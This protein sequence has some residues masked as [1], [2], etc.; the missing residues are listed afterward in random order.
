MNSDIRNYLKI[1]LKKKVEKKCNKNGYIDEVYRILHN[2][3]ND[4]DGKMPPEHLNGNAIYNIT[5]HCRICILIEN[6]IIISQVKI[7]NQELIVTINGPIMS[8]IPRD[9]IDT[10]VWNINDNFINKNTKTKLNIGDFVKIQIINKKLNNGDT[11]IK[12]ICKL[13]DFATEKEIKEYYGSNILE[14]KVDNFII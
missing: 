9:N 1:N 14:E 5:Y 7:I 8:F 12:S 4:D 10:S 6:K 2:D 13:L 3:D 11:Q